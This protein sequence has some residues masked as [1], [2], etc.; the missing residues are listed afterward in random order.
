MAVPQRATTGS[1][2]RQEPPRLITLFGLKHSG[3]TSVAQRVSEA[4]GWPWD[5]LDR[6]TLL[7]AQKQSLA[8]PNTLPNAAP[9]STIR[10]LWSVVDPRHFRAIEASALRQSL[11]QTPPSPA[12]PARLLSLGG[13]I[14]DNRPAMHMLRH[15]P[16]CS[17]IYLR[18]PADMLYKRIIARGIPPFLRDSAIPERSPQEI[19]SVLAA[20]RSAQCQKYAQYTIDVADRAIDEIAAMVIAFF[21]KSTPRQ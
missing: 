15:S 2:T 6:L 12:T 8:R 7:H 3:K 17:L 19:W 1:D 13:G 9:F 5:D 10:Q 16:R 14:I 4:T 11:A 20:R 18:A 21:K